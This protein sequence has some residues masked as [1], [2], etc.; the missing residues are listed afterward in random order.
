MRKTLDKVT[1]F[2]D[3]CK[4]L[5]Q[6]IHVVKVLCSCEHLEKKKEKKRRPIYHNPA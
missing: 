4:V 6:N 2:I 5:R 3:K 1:R